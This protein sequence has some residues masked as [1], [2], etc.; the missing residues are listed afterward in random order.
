MK[1]SFSERLFAV[2]VFFFFFLLLYSPLQQT[3]IW[4]PIH[5]RMTILRRVYFVKLLPNLLYSSM[6]HSVIN[7]QKILIKK[8]RLGLIDF[9]GGAFF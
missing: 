5:T 3:N 4:T 6:Y 7:S 8:K 2:F 9:S 1:Q